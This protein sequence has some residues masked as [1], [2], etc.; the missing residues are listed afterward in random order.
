M[1]DDDRQTCPSCGEPNA[2]LVAGL[3]PRCLLGN[4]LGGET[5]AGDDGTTEGPGRPRED[6]TTDAMTTALDSDTRVVLTVN[7]GPGAIPAAAP[8]A[9][10][11]RLEL[12]GEIARGGMGVVLRCRD[13]DL[14]RE[15]AVKVL[16]DDLRGNPEMIRRFVEEAQIAGQLQHP[17]IVPIHELGSFGDDRPYFTMKLVKGRTLS[18]LL[19]ESGPSE[20]D[21]ARFLGIFEQVC[22]TVAY[23]HAHGVIHRDLKPSN[24]MV[25]A[26]GEVQV[27]DWGL[28]KVLPRCAR[29]QSAGPVEAPVP[30]TVIATVRSKTDS[31]LSSA[32]SVLGTPSYMAPEQARGEVDRLDERVDVFAL[33]SI[34]CEILTGRPAFVGRSSDAMLRTAAQGDVGDALARLDASGADA[35]L[36]ALARDC[37][38]PEREDR[39]RDAGAVAGRLT[40]Y[41]AGVQE[42][43]RAA[44][45]ARA[46]ESARAEEATRTAEAARAQARAERRTR[47]MTAVLA[48]VGVVLV[49]LL[50]GGAVW[51]QRRDAAQAATT[52]RLVNDA[53]AEALRREGE[54]GS[55]AINDPSGWDAALTEAHRADDLAN[56]GRPDAALRG[57]VDSVLATLTRRRDEAS[58]RAERLKVDR[59]LLADLDAARNGSDS[60]TGY[61]QNFA[62]AFMAVGNSK[63]TMS[64]RA[65]G[66]LDGRPAVAGRPRRLPR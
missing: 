15:L 31:D 44:E 66:S 59:K 36:L 24:V 5:D 3:C 23:A 19:G 57:R 26:F 43:L 54:A 8:A 21:R 1:A 4:A 20:A 6:V 42:R 51:L 65:V 25:G 39:P 16:R 40:A 55:R 10:P 61:D 58:Q 48:T 22:Q 28:A 2:T 60:P 45:V 49:A 35:D 47:R 38:A 63:W 52:T 62:A 50:G 56:Q 17:G 34:L 53:L 30:E 33:G 13:P 64:S 9:R 11:S 27:M 46:A 12:F 32:G 14:G 41:L 29:D 37:L 7:D 18:R